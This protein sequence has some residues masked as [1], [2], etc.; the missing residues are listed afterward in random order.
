MKL[1]I[2]KWNVDEVFYVKD[3]KTNF[4]S[5]PKIEGL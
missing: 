1:Y 4:H 3:A 5:K 2:F